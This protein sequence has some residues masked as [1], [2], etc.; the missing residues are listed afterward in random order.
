MLYEPRFST[1]TLPSRSSTSPRGARSA[2]VRRWLFSAI[3]RERRVLHDL[4]DPEADREHR[5]QE[6]DD[7]LQGRQANHLP[8][9]VVEKR[10][11]QRSANTPAETRCGS[12]SRHAGVVEKSRS[13]QRPQRPLSRF[14]RILCELCVLCVEPWH[15]SRPLR[16]CEGCGRDGLKTVPYVKQ[17]RTVR[18][19]HHVGHVL[20]G[21]PD[22]SNAAQPVRACR[23]VTI[24]AETAE[25]AE[26]ILQDSLRALRA[27]R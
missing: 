4:Q 6:G 2:S 13:P 8:A 3:S 1:S 14:F 12:V 9:A 11:V 19:A 20:Q 27:P 16:G 22:P 23:E 26:Q 24:T 18:F 21:V 7:V 5:E 10:H 17:E 15:F 25:T